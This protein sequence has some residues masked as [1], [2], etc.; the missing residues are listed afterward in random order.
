MKRI[1]ILLFF[2][3]LQAVFLQASASIGVIT[4]R[5]SVCPGDTVTVADTT[6]G[7][8]W[9]S[10]NPLV[11]DISPAG[12]ISALAAGTSVITY[13]VPGAG[14]TTLML[15][16]NRVASP[17]VTIKSGSP[18]GDTVCTGEY[19]TLT[20]T[21]TDGGSAP[22]YLWTVN[23]SVASTAGSY[24]Y[25]PTDGDIVKVQLTSDMPCAVW[26]TASSTTRIAVVVPTVPVVYIT[27]SQGL[28]VA[29]RSHAVLT[30]YVT[31][32]GA[33]PSYQWVVNNKA[34]QGATTNVYATDTLHNNDS[35]SCIVRN[36]DLCGYGTF[37]SISIHVYPAGLAMVSSNEPTLFPNPARGA[38]TVKNA[39]GAYLVI[40]DITGR[41]VYTAQIMSDKVTVNFED[42]HSG[43]YIAQLLLAHGEQRMVKLVKE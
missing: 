27:C 39:G 16:V 10:S 40:A 26:P 8:T 22:Q 29:E 30:A 18:Y 34:V 21:T 37:N 36:N 9:S 43:V 23:G 17:A 1:F 2:V 28:N 24:S 15:T 31:D 3:C 7:G 6:A 33:G 13:M 19:L 25:V 12:F 35:V 11:A 4:G 5:S 20:S 42:L 41:Q 38:L 14:Y 32:G